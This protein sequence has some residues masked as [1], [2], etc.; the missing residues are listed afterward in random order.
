MEFFT[1]PVCLPQTI[2]WVDSQESRYL[3]SWDYHTVLSLPGTL[4][5]RIV[6]LPPLEGVSIQTA[7]SFL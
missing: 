5:C 6:F 7:L 3:S 1:E 2:A 4:R